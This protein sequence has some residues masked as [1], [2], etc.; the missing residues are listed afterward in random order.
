MKHFDVIIIGAGTAGLSARKEVAKKTQNYLIVDRGPLGTTCAR[1]GCMPS[2]VLIQ[3]ANDIHQNKKLISMGLVSVENSSTNIKD[4][5][6]HVR[7]LRDRF[8]SSVLS[9]KDNWNDK[10]I[11]GE[12]TFI[13][14]NTL[15]INGE[16]FR[17]DK[18]IVA[19]GS[20][21][22]IPKEW[23][24]YK[25]F[26]LDT[27]SLFELETLP[28]KM[29]VVGLGAIGFEMGQALSRLGVKVIGVNKSPSLGGLSDPELQEYVALHLNREFKIFQSDVK[30]VGS[31]EESQVSAEIEGIIHK[32]DK[33]LVCV[34]RKPNIANLQLEKA[35]AVLDEKGIPEFSSTNLSLKKL[36]HIFIA[37][38]ANAYRPILHE[39]SDE[40]KIAGYNAVHETQCFKRKVSLGITF[41]DPNIA[42]IGEKFSSLKKENVNFITGKVSFEGQGRAIVKLQEQGLLH[43]Y[44][45]KVSG[46]ILG[47]E[48]Q[49]PSGE[50]IAH[51]LAWVISMDMTISEVLKLPFYHPV[52]EEG[53]RTA[54]RDA[55]KQMEHFEDELMN[56][57]DSPIR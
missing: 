16:T 34:G 49:A 21:P 43:V 47:A 9:G 17:A 51:L 32:F 25:K 12:A 1:V 7:A 57:D 15:E 39:A 29:L 2:K 44:I 48:L 36:P 53:L 5:M 19:T 26:F 41:S 30:F 42:M 38:D 28:E 40:G 56:C 4:V 54:L 14:S 46:K 8:V 31:S 27:D 50:H 11:S 55:S 52:V 13:N 45:D 10:F 37:G 18:V 22:L 20:S 6:I 24:D 3:V 23:L 33:V 35:G